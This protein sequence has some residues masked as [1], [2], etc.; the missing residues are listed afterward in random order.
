MQD[1]KVDTQ[2]E[3]GAGKKNKSRKQLKRPQGEIK[4]NLTS[5][6]GGATPVPAAN[7]G[8][9]KQVGS[10]LGIPKLMAYL[11]AASTICMD[12][13]GP[14]CKICIRSTGLASW[15][16]ALGCSLPK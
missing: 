15:V 1:G 14:I 16:P 11:Q 13:S 9:A 4:T 8:E 5:V 12:Q 6:W 7:G 10:Q 2:V 3:E